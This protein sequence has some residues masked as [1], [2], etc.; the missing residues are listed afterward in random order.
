MQVINENEKKKKRKNLKNSNY[1]YLQN[2]KYLLLL[3]HKVARL[4]ITFKI[5]GGNK[6][7]KR[8]LYVQYVV[9]FTQE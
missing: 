9:M 1:Y 5:I 2:E 6:K 3:V 4:P 7:W 8:N